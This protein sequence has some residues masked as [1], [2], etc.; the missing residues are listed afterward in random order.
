MTADPT[1]FPPGH[2]D[3][4]WMKEAIRVAQVSR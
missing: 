2:P 4:R 1:P 3:A